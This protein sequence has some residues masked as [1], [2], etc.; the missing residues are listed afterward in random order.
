MGTLNDG[1][2][3]KLFLKLV[4]ASFTLMFAVSA[5]SAKRVASPTKFIQGTING[6]GGKG[7]RCQKNGVTAIETLDL[8]EAIILYNLEI[9]YDPK[10]EEEAIDLF[11]T[12]ITRHFWNPSTIAMPEFKEGFKARLNDLLL[13]KIKFLTDG[14][15]L[16]LIDDSYEPIIEENCEQVQVAAYYDES[17]LLIDK[18][19][20][21]QMNWTNRIAL[22]THEMIYAMDRA[23]GASNSMSARK[24]VGQLYS[25]TGARPKAD[26]VPSDNRKIATCWVSEKD[27][28]VGYFYAY[29]HMKVINE[30]EVRPGVE[31]VFNFLKNSS[32]LFRTSAFIQTPSLEDI[33]S[34]NYN[35]GTNADLEVES[36]PS[37]S[38]LAI[39]FS[40]EGKA[41]LLIK[42]KSNG[43]IS[44]ELDV[45]CQMMH[46]KNLDKK[47]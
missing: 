20:W 41:K 23:N 2:H 28:T 4:L 25:T 31:F 11:A 24:L 3:V 45:S 34:K 14:R 39:R 18:S 32:F 36:Y 8:Y 22:L 19:L 6:G 5:Q 37:N 1:G 46:A 42:N 30:P 16:K 13:K 29:D 33:F 35:L 17:V 27:I 44:N 26:G 40:G 12:L 7:V 47:K 43:N 15:K 21:D 38:Y 10:T 9:G